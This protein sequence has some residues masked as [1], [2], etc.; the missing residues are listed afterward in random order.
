VTEGVYAVAIDMRNRPGG[1]K[2]E[3]AVQKT[4]TDCVTWL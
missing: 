3:V 4:N 2:L 1:A